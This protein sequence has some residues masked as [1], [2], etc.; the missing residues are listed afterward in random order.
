MSGF[1]VENGGRGVANLLNE[2]IIE[3]LAKRLFEED[4]DDLR[5]AKVVIKVGPDG[6]FRFR[7]NRA[8]V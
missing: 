5:G 7:V 4:E 3:P 6:L 1:S 2:R 8:E